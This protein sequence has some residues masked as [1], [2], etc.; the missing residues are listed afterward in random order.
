MLSNQ[1]RVDQAILTGILTA[2][3]VCCE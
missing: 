2:R 1:V 3:I